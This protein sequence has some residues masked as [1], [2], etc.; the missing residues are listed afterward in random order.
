M[1]SW[2]ASIAEDRATDRSAGRQRDLRALNGRALHLDPRLGQRAA[3]PCTNDRTSGLRAAGARCIVVRHRERVHLINPQTS[4][5]AFPPPGGA[6]SFA[7]S[8]GA[9]HC[10]RMRRPKEMINPV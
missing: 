1:R 2:R 7:N 4:P 9:S 5:N 8:A 10:S 6:Y 3:P